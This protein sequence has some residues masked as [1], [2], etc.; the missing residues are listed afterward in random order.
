MGTS[1]YTKQFIEFFDSDMNHVLENN[2][3]FN[4]FEEIIDGDIF[5]KLWANLNKLEICN[6][7]CKRN[8]I[9]EDNYRIN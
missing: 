1:Y 4:T 5:S 9:D 3:K 2:L 7:K 8:E 6:I